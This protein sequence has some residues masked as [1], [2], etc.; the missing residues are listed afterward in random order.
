[1]TH[2]LRLLV[3]LMLALAA[4]GATKYA[5]AKKAPAVALYYQHNAPLEDLKVFDIVVVEPDHG[6][7]P[8]TLRTKGTEL[9]A[10]TSVAEVQPTRAY[11]K[12]IPAQWQMARNGHWN[13]VVV[14]QTPAQ[15]PAFFADQVVAPLWQ[16][17]YRGFFLDTMYS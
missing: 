12:N 1:M 5:Q 6:Y 17:G 14:D 4:M 15:W 10:Y 13:S 11:F 8:L 7:D 2:P 3:L 9:Y 16:R